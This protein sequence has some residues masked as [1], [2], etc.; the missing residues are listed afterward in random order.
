MEWIRVDNELPTS[1]DYY[2]VC[3]FYKSIGQ[4]VVR[5]A[6]FS[7]VDETF[8]TR[9]VRGAAVLFPA[10]HWQDLAAPPETP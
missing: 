5:A 6:W 9:D 7:V 1:Y 10:T 8:V 2:Q 4:W 3:H